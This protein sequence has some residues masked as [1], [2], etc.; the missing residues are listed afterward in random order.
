MKYISSRIQV[1]VKV[2]VE[3]KT[4]KEREVKHQVDIVVVV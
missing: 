4:F 2:G 1:E 3:I